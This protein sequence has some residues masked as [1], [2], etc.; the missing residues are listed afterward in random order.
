[1]MT[2]KESLLDLPPQ[3][4]RRHDSAAMSICGVFQSYRTLRWHVLFPVQGKGC[5]YERHKVSPETP[6]PRYEASED[7]SIA[8]LS[9]LYE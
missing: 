2:T 3:G 6:T 5:Q 9:Q 1:M 7:E 4:K 8:H